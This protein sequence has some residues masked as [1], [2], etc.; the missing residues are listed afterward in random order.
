MN[1][2]QA[3]ASVH[4]AINDLFAIRPLLSPREA[5]ALLNQFKLEI[6]IML[7]MVDEMEKMGVPLDGVQHD[8]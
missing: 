5:R 2:E 4:R 7:A 6:D 3:T 1:I 8:H